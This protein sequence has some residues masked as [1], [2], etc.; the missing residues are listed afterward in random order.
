[1]YGMTHS[2][3]ENLRPYGLVASETDM[4]V[5]NEDNTYPDGKAGESGVNTATANAVE[6]DDAGTAV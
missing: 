1:M 5:D 3:L 6:D 4:F 2:S